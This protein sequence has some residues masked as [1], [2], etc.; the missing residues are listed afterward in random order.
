MTT[1]TQLNEYL[2]NRIKFGVN[3]KDIV[4]QPILILP[5]TDDQLKR[6]F[7]LLGTFK[8]CNKKNILGKFT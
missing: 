4:L 1:R 7:V 6:I 5:N 8:C 3:Y 2:K